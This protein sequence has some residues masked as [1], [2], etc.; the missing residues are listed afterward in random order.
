VYTFIA[1]NQPKSGVLRVCTDKNVSNNKPLKNM[2]GQKPSTHALRAK[3]TWKLPGP[4]PRAYAVY[5][6]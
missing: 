2:D 4:A 3:G 6:D 1:P 5:V